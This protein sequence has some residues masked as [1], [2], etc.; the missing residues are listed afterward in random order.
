M[1]DEKSIDLSSEE[2]SNDCYQRLYKPGSKF[3]KSW[4][5]QVESFVKV[6]KKIET[7]KRLKNLKMAKI[8]NIEKR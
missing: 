2:F 5:W 4:N 3:K 7:L 1:K 6:E 8:V